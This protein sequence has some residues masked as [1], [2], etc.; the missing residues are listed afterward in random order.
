MI[1]AVIL[2]A[3]QSVRMGCPKLLLKVGGQTILE[4]VVDAALAS[5]LEEII[6]VLGHQ[7]DEPARLL[8]GR[9]VKLVYNPC[10]HLGQSTSLAAGIKAVDKRTR[11]IM[12]ILADQPLLTADLINR[13]VEFFNSA[14]YLVVK[15]VFNGRYGHPVIVDSGLIPELLVLKGDVGA[16]E[17]I[18]RYWERTGL[19]P[20]ED[21][22]LLQDMDTPADLKRLFRL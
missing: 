7:A 4:R 20:V 15:P 8:A 2:A 6:V 13:L 22:L 17:I 11:G 19:L 10:Y 9:Q 1:S 3:G 18:A 14:H 21:E 12:F 5:T 16:R